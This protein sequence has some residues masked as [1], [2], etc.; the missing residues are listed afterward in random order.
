MLSIADSSY[1]RTVVLK[2]VWFKK[3][4]KGKKKI[5]QNLVNI[6]PVTNTSFYNCTVHLASFLSSGQGLQEETQF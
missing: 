5:K 4:K 1:S 2:C 6:Y 3:K